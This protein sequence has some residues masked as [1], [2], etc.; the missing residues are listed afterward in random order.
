MSTSPNGHTSSRQSTSLHSRRL[1]IHLPLC[2]SRFSTEASTLP[3]QNPTEV[4]VGGAPPRICSIGIALM[5]FTLFADSSV[6]SWPRTSCPPGSSE[7]PLGEAKWSAHKVC[8]PLNDL[9]CWAVKRSWKA[10]LGGANSPLPTPA[11]TSPALLQRTT[12]QQSQNTSNLGILSPARY[13]SI[14]EQALLHD[15]SAITSKQGKCKLQP[16]LQL[17]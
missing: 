9:L 16:K 3:R 14:V 4:G 11:P 17:R 10:V 8:M 6:P 7:L 12:P 2:P 5:R 15:R 1:V 13:L